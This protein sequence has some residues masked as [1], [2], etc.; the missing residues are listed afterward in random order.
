VDRADQTL[1]APV[2]ADR[3]TRRLD[4]A[5]QR[6][7]TDEP[8]APDGVQQLLFGHDPPPFPDQHRQQVEDLRLERTGLAGLAQL[9]AVQIQLTVFEGEGHGTPQPHATHPGAHQFPT[10]TGRTAHAVSR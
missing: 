4:P 9:E 1:A 7:L 3:L 8:V 6:R 10:W 2:V 5:G